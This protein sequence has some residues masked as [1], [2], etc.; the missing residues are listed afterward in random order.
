VSS[1]LPKRTGPS[2]QWEQLERKENQL[3][4]YSLILLLVLAGGF[5]FFAWGSLRTVSQ[6]L[7]AV[8]IGIVVLLLL[9]G[10]YVWNWRRE[11][12]ELRGFI[13][14]FQEHAAAPPSEK[15]VE[16]LLDVLAR[17]Q[18]GYRELIDSLDHAVFALHLDG[19]IHVVNRR[20]SEI[21][22]KPFSEIVRHSLDEFLTE[23]TR[24]QALRGLAWF[25]EKRFWSGVLTVRLK[26]TGELRFFDC[27]F[28]AV[29]HEGEVSGISGLARDVTSQRE[30]EARFTQL[31]E[32]LQEGVYFSTPEGTLL[33]VNPAFVRMLGY[34]GK[35][36]LLAIDARKLYPDPAG[37]V[38]WMKEIEKKGA[39]QDRQVT[40]LR[41][42]GSPIQC[43]DSCSAM[44][45]TEGRVVRYQGA[46]V[47]MTHRLE[48]E[49]R[50]HGEQ[51]FVRRLIDCFP[52]IIVVL[53]TEGRY[54]FVS[55]RIQEISGYL[56]EEL[57]GRFVGERA[58]PEDQPALSALVQDLISGTITGG[59][60]EYRARDKSE[61]WRI[62]RATAAPL[63]DADGRIT[64]VV[65]S[66]RD[67]TETKKLEQQLL[68]TEKLAAM[69][70]M[71]AGVA[72]ELNNPLTAILGVSDL[73]RERAT[74]D[75]SR[76]Q[77]ELVNQQARRAAHIVQSLLAF[78]RPS[79]PSRARIRLDDL[80]QRVLQLQEHS[81]RKN[82]IAVEVR[83]EPDLPVIEGDPNQLHQV[84]LNLVV[85][86]EQ[87]IH[88]VR[89]H[90]VIRIRFERDEGNVA[91]A[92]EDDG[93]GIRPEILARI[94]DP[95]FTT[96]RPGGGT[97]LGLT[98]CLAIAKEHGG[99]VEF[100]DAPGGGSLFRVILPVRASSAPEAAPGR[101]TSDLAAASLR[102]HS[103]LVVDDEE[104]IRELVQ[105]G[106][107]ARGMAV[108]CVA[109][110]EEA[111][112]R[113][114]TRSY[115]AVLCDYH[116]PDSN[117]Q[118]LLD[119]LQSRA[120]S[121][122]QRY[123]VMTGELLDSE[124]FECLRQKGTRVVQKPFQVSELAAVLAEVLEPVGA[125]R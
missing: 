89:D 108:D 53:D 117:G 111:L 41:K 120:G 71:I 122:S 78:S 90:G 57:V 83:S 114:A 62:L 112:A 84:F 124:V 104:A 93:P 119:H 40:L 10:L 51:E 70:Q 3:W 35:G 14:G 31:F 24:E 38:Q 99:S 97:G 44:R 15:Q 50:L 12:A 109:N 54:T 121:S 67:V 4:R 55:A 37:R 28:H 96:K 75:P 85:N 87:A 81:L 6:H 79:A 92:F 30:A 52:D 27:M 82:Q 76:R 59:Q 34:E 64:G 94:F 39:Q 56:P 16:H 123:L 98:I 11:I 106:L 8:P 2:S 125:K 77:I 1:N 100:Q 105:L 73:L 88:E 26:K 113:I 5:A 110:A 66:A 9:F 20:F 80:V 25:V 43:L 21:V 86:A 116:L 107:S 29:V 95:F 36:E 42:D 7:Q 13:R 61:S 60:V 74:D 103:V 19:T 91:V 33:D 45:D 32:A 58:D 118:D 69:G 101:S 18:H 68:Q 17:S 63:Y 115:D 47:D 49:K 23:P 102:G 48:I 65:A 72:H 46:L 22:G